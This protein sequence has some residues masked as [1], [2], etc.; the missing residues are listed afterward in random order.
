MNPL[1]DPSFWGAPRTCA[2]QLFSFSCSF[3]Q[4]SGQIIGFFPKLRVWHPLPRLGNPESASETLS[5]TFLNSLN[6][7]TNF[8]WF[9]KVPEIS[10]TT[11]TT[12]VVQYHSLLADVFCPE[13]TSLKY[14]KSRSLTPKL[15]LRSSRKH[16]NG[17]IATIANFVV[18]FFICTI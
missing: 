16:K 1:V 7:S 8:P 15:E 4:K 14:G 2:P 3:R 13:T 5:C 17:K 9:F 11:A 6:I 10:T 12:W 18:S